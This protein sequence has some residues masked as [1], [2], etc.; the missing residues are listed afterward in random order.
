MDVPP[1][2]SM[3]FCNTSFLSHHFQ[4]PV[5]GVVVG[6]PAQSRAFLGQV[7]DTLWGY[8]IKSVWF[9]M[10]ASLGEN[11]RVRA[12]IMAFVGAVAK[13]GSCWAGLRLGRSAGFSTC[14][15]V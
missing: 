6:V 2:L 4:S 9:L 12:A 13:R 5:R 11:G 8:I 14:L 15:V 7:W 1:P 10:F 3:P